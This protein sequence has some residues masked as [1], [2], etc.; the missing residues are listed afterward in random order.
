MDNPKFKKNQMV[1]I[2]YN[3]NIARICY[4][5]DFRESGI[6]YMVEVVSKHLTTRGNLMQDVLEAD[7][8]LDLLYA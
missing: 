6:Y 3:G 4:L 8:A 5:N 2:K 7:E 1:R